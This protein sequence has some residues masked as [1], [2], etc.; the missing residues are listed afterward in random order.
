M[1]NTLR[2]I[3]SG[4]VATLVLS[5]VILLKVQFHI[6]PELS[7]LAQISKLAGGTVGG[8]MDHFII[9][10][11]VWGI[12]FAGFDSVTP[13]L[14]SWLKGLMFSVLAWLVTMV[15]FL[16]FVGLG[17]FGLKVGFEPAAINLVQHLIYGLVLGVTYGLLGSFA[18]AKA[19]EQSR[20][21]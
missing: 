8:W 3:I 21:T 14:P 17:L 16:P 7:V 20:Q 11:L 2:A 4:F 12:L 5:A 19:P 13:P 15:C 18:S 1:S 10:T 9:G 6:S